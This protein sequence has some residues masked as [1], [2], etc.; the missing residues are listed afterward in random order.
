MKFL[1]KLLIAVL[2]ALNTGVVFAQDDI[3]IDTGIIGGGK[4]QGAKTS[5]NQ[6]T[7]PVLG[8]NKDGNTEINALSG[9][10]VAIGA[11]KTPGAYV[12]SSGIELPSGKG[13]ASAGNVIVPASTPVSAT[14]FILPGFNVFPTFAANASALLPTG[15]AALLNTPY[16]VCSANANAGR[17]LSQGTPGIGTANTPGTYAPLAA[18]QC[19][20]CHLN[21]PTGP[22][23]CN[24]FT[25]VT[26][27]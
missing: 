26:P 24:T 27:A 8:V 19:M 5:D 17:V 3:S 9:K 7:V 23:Y 11:N 20:I 21:V 14:N 22:W 13:V 25:V 16:I 6:T 10:K 12:S 15:T 18:A 1:N 4:Y 2:L